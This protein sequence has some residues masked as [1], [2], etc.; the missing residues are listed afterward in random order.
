[1]K[2]QRTKNAARNV[3][4]G[5]MLRVMNMIVPFIMRTVMLHCL[6]TEY[7]GLNGLLRSIL[8]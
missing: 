8:S 3:V 6:G 2:I 1:M 5:G 7:L 4:Y